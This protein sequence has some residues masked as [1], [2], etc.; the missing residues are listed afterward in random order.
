MPG[1]SFPGFIAVEVEP[2]PAD[3]D[4]LCLRFKRASD[5]A[6]LHAVDYES[7][8]GL[9]G[10]WTLWAVDDPEGLL[11]RA[12]RSVLVD[13]SSDGLSHL[14]VGGRHGL[15][16]QHQET[17]AVVRVPYLLLAARTRPA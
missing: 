3:P 10:T 2:G 1:M 13:D 5:D 6:P 11:R 8:D 17:G 15:L 7:D 9:D 14:L 16:L 12:A 4:G